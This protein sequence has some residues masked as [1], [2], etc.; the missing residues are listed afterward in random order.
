[1]NKLISLIMYLLW[2]AT[3]IAILAMTFTSFKYEDLNLIAI[4]LLV[5]AS[6]NSYFATNQ[7]KR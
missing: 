2:I 1:M 6:V 4:V 5:F 3:I 7:N